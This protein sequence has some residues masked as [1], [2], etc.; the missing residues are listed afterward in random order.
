M[1]IKVTAFPSK[2]DFDLW[3][4]DHDKWIGSICIGEECYVTDPYKDKGNA[5][6]ELRGWWDG[7]K[8]QIEIGFEF[9]KEEEL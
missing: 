6:A 8:G 7:V 5:L 1:A 9:Y 2:V 3:Q 4:D